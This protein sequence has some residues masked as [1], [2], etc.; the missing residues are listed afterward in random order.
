MLGMAGEAGHGPLEYDGPLCG[1]EGH[2]CLEVLASAT[3]VSAAW[4]EEVASESAGL[5]SARKRAA[6]ITAREVAELADGGR[7]GRA[8]RCISKV[9][10]YLGLSLAQLVNT[11]NLPLYVIGGGVV[12]SWHLFAPRCLRC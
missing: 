3:A 11:L 4:R 10:K 1:C 2:G 8:D 5:A 12:H 9:G 7:R 6:G